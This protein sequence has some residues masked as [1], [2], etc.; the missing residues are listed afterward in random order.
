MPAPECQVS[1]GL[2]KK[3]SSGSEL[4]PVAVARALT[5][6]THEPIRLALYF[7]F[8]RTICFI[9]DFLCSAA[10]IEPTRLQAQEIVYCRINGLFANMRMAIIEE[11]KKHT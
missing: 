6:N 8:A 2:L 10:P 4:M 7:I 5:N 1:Y 11:Q 3:W 9:V